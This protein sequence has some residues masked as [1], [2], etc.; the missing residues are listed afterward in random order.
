MLLNYCY[1]QI[2]FTYQILEVLPTALNINPILIS[3][4]Q[5]SILLHTIILYLRFH[6]DFN[7]QSTTYNLKTEYV[8]WFEAEATLR[9][10][11]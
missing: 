11:K 2:N 9:G 6:F 8:T 4:T 5:W 10:I 3:I 1:K 7:V